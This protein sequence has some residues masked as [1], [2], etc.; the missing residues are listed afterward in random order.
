MT[1]II[2]DVRGKGFQNLMKIEDAIEIVKS[3]INRIQTTIQ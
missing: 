2:V 3:K 1:K